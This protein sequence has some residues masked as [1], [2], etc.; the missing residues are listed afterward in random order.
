M[1]F[2]KSA[3]SGSRQHR[4]CRGNDSF[5]VRKQVLW[6]GAQLPGRIQEIGDVLLEAAATVGRRVPARTLQAAR[7]P[8]AVLGAAALQTGAGGGLVTKPFA[9]VP[10]VS[11]VKNSPVGSE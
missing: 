11:S 5:K 6:V 4:R 1:F 9:P 10:L 7:L 2:W 8:L 3:S